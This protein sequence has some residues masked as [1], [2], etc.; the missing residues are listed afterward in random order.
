MGGEAGTAVVGRVIP[1]DQQGF[2][3]AHVRKIVPALAR[4]VRQVV[5]LTDTVRIDQVGG[6]QVIGV[7]RRCVQQGQRRA[8]DGPTYGAPEV[9]LNYRDCRQRVGLLAAQ[10]VAD[11][12]RP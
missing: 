7:E 5:D 10:D 8:F 11:T 6:Q 4:I 12:L 1:F 2:V 3:T 9:D